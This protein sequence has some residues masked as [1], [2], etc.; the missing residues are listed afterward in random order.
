MPANPPLQPTLWR[1]S[2]AI[3]NHTRLKIFGWL[4]DQRG[5]TVSAVATHLKQP[6][7]VASQYLRSLEARGLLVARRIGRHVEYRLAAENRASLTQGLAA[8][9]RSAFRRDSAAAKTIF[10]LATAFTHPRRIEIFR[11]LSAKP[12]SMA[13]I[14]TATGIPYLAS[15][16]HL[17]KLEA[18]GFIVCRHGEYH[19]VER[20][21]AVGR[22]LARMAA[23]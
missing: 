9:L 14:V 1:T 22:E 11:A 19:V 2:R 20:S 7:P 8:A 16:R 23:S 6:L 15:H 21:D 17:K 5:Q 18:R 4:V 12:M 10:R 13:Q 3:A